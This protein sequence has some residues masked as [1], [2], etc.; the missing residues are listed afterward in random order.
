MCIFDENRSK[1]NGNR[2]KIDVQ[3]KTSVSNK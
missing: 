1:K 3:K 2:K